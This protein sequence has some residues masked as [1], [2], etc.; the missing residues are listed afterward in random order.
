[1]RRGAQPV[2]APRPPR[3]IRWSWLPVVLVVAVVLGGIGYLRVWP[4]L[5][6]VMS[7]S[8][9]PT[10]NTGDMVLLKRLDAPAQIG[11]ITVITVP[12]EVRSR[13]G[14]P[15]VVIHRVMRIAPDG[16]VTTKGDARK[17]PDPFTIPRSALTTKVVGTV[18]AAGRVIAFLSS[19]LGLLWLAGGA[20][21]FLGMPLLDRYRNAQ[22]REQGEA[23]DLHASLRAIT[24][25]LTALRS[26]RLDE[27]ESLE[28]RLEDATRAATA[29]Q[30]QL[31]E[32]TAAF[33]DHLERLPAQ[34]E[35]LVAAAVRASA[36]PAAPPAPAAPRTP[37]VLACVPASQWKPPAP[38]APPV[39]TAARL[40]GSAWDAR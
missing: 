15:P 23:D 20:A 22:Q 14:Y 11:D 5:A 27:R 37:S 26:D 6:T 9:A 3:R 16:T 29:A 7:A 35:R 38:P 33:S 18:P 13:Y 31:A 40:V 10:I 21:L 4:P 25:D 32:V 2:A 34:I 12:D 19:G 28:S 1:V 24:A 30:E 17:E 36:L 8:M 39:P